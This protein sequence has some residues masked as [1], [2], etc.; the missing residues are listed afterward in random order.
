MNR[1]VLARLAAG[2][3]LSLAVGIANSAKAATILEYDFRTAPNGSQQLTGTSSVAGASTTGQI[4]DYN[5]DGTGAY[6]AVNT[7]TAMGPGFV[8]PVKFG[9]IAYNGA[10]SGSG[11]GMVTKNTAVTGHNNFW[12]DY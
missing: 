7:G 11:D 2:A 8:D 4:V 10:I 6:P 3:A 12:T 9:S 1:S 5:G